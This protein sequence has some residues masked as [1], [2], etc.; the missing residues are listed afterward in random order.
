M[1]RQPLITL[2]PEDIKWYRQQRKR[3][4]VRGFVALLSLVL[5]IFY[6]L[7]LR[8]GVRFSGTLLLAL[9]GIAGTG[10]RIAWL[11]RKLRN[12]LISLQQ[13]EEQ[14]SIAF[15]DEIDDYSAWHEVKRSVIFV[16]VLLVS[17][18]ALIS[19][20]LQS[21]ADEFSLI[22]AGIIVLVGFIRIANKT[23]DWLK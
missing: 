9:A 4:L 17:P 7:L 13:A 18:M 11:E 1:N 15:Y 12:R 21:Y 16:L 3:S 2:D 14:D 20:L 22:V 8:E 23:D 10:V 19:V 5:P 6:L